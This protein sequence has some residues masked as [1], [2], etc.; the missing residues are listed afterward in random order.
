MNQEAIQTLYSLAVEEGYDGE[1][2]EFFSLLQTNPEAVSTA[3][4]LARDEGYTKSLE[5][6]EVLLGLKKKE[7]NFPD[8]FS[9]KYPSSNLPLDSKSPGEPEGVGIRS[10][11][12]LLRRAGL[13]G[14]TRPIIDEQP[15]EVTDNL[16]QPRE[17][18]PEDIGPKPDIQRIPTRQATAD[19]PLEREKLAQPSPEKLNQTTFGDELLKRSSLSDN[20][21]LIIKDLPSES[22]GGM[23]KD[24]SKP[25]L[26]RNLIIGEVIDEISE[27]ENIKNKS[28]LIGLLDANPELVEKVDD[29]LK[30]KLEAY[31][32]TTQDDSFWKYRSFEPTKDIHASRMLGDRTRQ[33]GEDDPADPKK[34]NIVQQLF[35]GLQ[36]VNLTELTNYIDEDVVMPQGTS[37]RNRVIEAVQEGNLDVL[38]LLDPQNQDA[39][40]IERN[41]LALDIE[42]QRTLRLYVEDKISFLNDRLSILQ[43]NP[44]KYTDEINKIKQERKDLI[45]SF[46]SYNR[47]SLPFL[48]TYLHSRKQELADKYVSGDMGLYNPGDII[49]GTWQGAKEIGKGGYGAVVDVSS[50]VL[51]KLGM[52]VWAEDLR[53]HRNL[54]NLLWKDPSSYAWAEGKVVMH[55]GKKYI[56]TPEGQV[57]DEE[58]EVDVAFFGNEAGIDLKAIREKAVKSTK[59]EVTQSMYGSDVLGANVTGNLAVQIVGMKGTGWVLKGLGGMTKAYGLGRMGRM[60]TMR[61]NAMIST[62]AV[63]YSSTY[64]QVLEE[65]REQGLP[66]ALGHKYASEI[67]TTTGLVGAITAVLISP[68]IGGQ[69]LFG[70]LT[71]KE[72]ARHLIKNKT[73]NNIPGKVMDFLRGGFTEGTFEAIQ[74]N[75][76]LISEEYAKQKINAE[77]GKDLFR[78]VLT[79]TSVMNN[80]IA[81]FA[82]AGLLGGAGR[83]GVSQVTFYNRL[84]SNQELFQKYMNMYVSQGLIDQIGA[85]RIVN[86][87]KNYHQYKNNLPKK[88]RFSSV[89]IKLTNLLAE[90]NRLKD[91]LKTQDEVFNE[92]TKTRIAAIDKEITRLSEGAVKGVTPS[93]DIL[94]GRK[95][96]DQEAIDAIAKENEARQARGDEL[97]EFTPENIFNKKQEILKQEQDASKK[98]G[99]V[100]ETSQDESVTTEEVVEGVPDEVQ[101]PSGT[102]DT[103]GQTDTDQTTEEEVKTEDEVVT[104]AESETEAENEAAIDELIKGQPTNKNLILEKPSRNKVVRSIKSLVRRALRRQGVNLNTTTGRARFDKEVNEALK[105]YGKRMETAIKI[106]NLLS[107]VLPTTKIYIAQ[108]SAEYLRLTKQHRGARSTN[109]HGMFIPSINT[110][111]VNGLRGNPIEVLAHEALH[112]ILYRKFGDN[113]AKIRTVTDRMMRELRRTLRNSKS[114]EL[115]ALDETLTKFT[116]RYRGKRSKTQTEEYLVEAFAILVAKYNTIAESSKALKIVEKFVKEVAKVLGIGKLGND[117]AKDPDRVLRALSK[118]AQK[119]KDGEEIVDSDFDILNQIEAEATETGAEATGKVKGEMEVQTEAATDEDVEVVGEVVVDEEVETEEDVTEEVTTEEEVV[120]D[121][122]VT[123]EEEAGVDEDIDMQIADLETEIENVKSELKKD[124]KQKG[125]DADQ[126]AD[127]RE[128]ARELIREY[129]AEIAQLKRDA[130]KTRKTKAEQKI[131]DLEEGIAL[132]KQRLAQA[133]RS[134]KQGSVLILKTEAELREYARELIKEYKSAI[135][136]IKKG[137]TPIEP[138]TWGEE[139][140]TEVKESRIP[141]EEG[142]A[143]KPSS[144]TPDAASTPKLLKTISNTIK[145]AVKESKELQ[146]KMRKDLMIKLRDAYKNGV[147]PVRQVRVLM[148]RLSKLNMDNPL[149]VNRFLEYTKRI[150]ADADNLFKLKTANT[151]RKRLRKIGKSKNIDAEISATAAN[152]ALLDPIY[153][154]DLDRYIE[155]AEELVKGSKTTRVRK[156]KITS[157]KAANLGKINSFVDTQLEIEKAAILKNMQAEFEALTGIDPSDMTY[158]EMMDWLKTNKEPSQKDESIIRKGIKKL[159]DKYSQTIKSMLS[160]GFD[161]A[162]GQK[163]SLDE[164]QRAIIKEFMNMDLDVMNVKDLI[165]A[166]EALNNFIV[167]QTTGGM[168]T[169]V[170]LNKGA[171]NVKGMVDQ[172]LTIKPLRKLKGLYDSLVLPFLKQFATLPMTLKNILGS[173]DNYVKFQVRSGLRD[174]IGGQARAIRE[175]KKIM[176]NYVDKFRNSMPNNEVFTSLLNNLERGVYAFLT[177]TVSGDLDSQKKEFKRRKRL[178]KQSIEKYKTGNREQRKTAEILETIYNKIKDVEST[179]DLDQHFNNTNMEAVRFWHNEWAKVYTDL[180]NVSYQIYNAILGNDVNYTP[181]RYSIFEGDSDIDLDNSSSFN[182]FTGLLFSKKAGVLFE[183]KRPNQLPG[184]RIINFDFDSNMSKAMESAKMDVETAPAYNQIKGFLQS[185]EFKKLIPDENLRKLVVDKITSYIND[186]KKQ[187]YVPGAPDSVYQKA[188]NFIANLGVGR[189]LAGVFQPVKQIVGVALNTIVTAKGNLDAKSL[190]NIDIQ[191]WINKVG[192]SVAIR[193]G[194][195]SADITKLDKFT[196]SKEFMELIKDP[197]NLPKIIKRINDFGLQKFLIN[198]DVAISRISFITYYKQKL[199][200]KGVNVEAIDWK[201]HEADPEALAYAEAQVDIMQNISSSEMFGEFFK[202]KNRAVSNARKLILPFASFAMNLKLRIWTNTA[203]LFSK[204]ANLDEKKLA[205]TALAGAMIEVGAFHTIGAVISM[206]LSKIGYDDD[207]RKRKQR[208]NNIIKGRKGSAVADFLS[209]I[210]SNLVDGQVLRAVNKAYELVTKEEEKIFFDAETST[211]DIYDVAGQ[212]GITL[213]KGGELQQ[214]FNLAYGDGEFTDKWGNKRKI[215]KDSQEELRLQVIPFFMYNLG[216][217]PAEFG[218]VG[219]YKLKSAME[220]GKTKKQR[221]K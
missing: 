197:R 27:F 172:G 137:K 97:I 8:L 40:D 87:V 209:P 34:L 4:D 218:T 162:T 36:G 186:V 12:D 139:Q 32:S 214:M 77:T 181:D 116:Q 220:T 25:L 154:E 52:D 80:T 57:I 203:T 198:P 170:R 101:Q 98:Q 68:N 125:L 73:T 219:R 22:R 153:V 156:G 111:I 182:L 85:D 161:L 115:K 21:K 110:I 205:A 96:K 208:V 58:R 71:A 144:P 143:K 179:A 94:E 92:D 61:T 49:G 28:D 54:N 216:V 109:T 123:T 51:D 166:V 213:E 201:N 193:G 120:V 66:D 191:N 164:S 83:V 62:G 175:T 10:A 202:S 133:L 81:A 149:A 221:S 82:S 33:I 159:F 24:M 6:F 23:S 102:G 135:A 190:F 152:F 180:A 114:D 146:N 56:V 67:A 165:K 168:E 17:I 16:L 95:I 167:N 145:K 11:D 69:Q 79:K 107:K 38:S 46:G 50:T 103:T 141:D 207:E 70:K 126:K 72:I 127:L 44:D 59:T 2:A 53:I 35:P 113:A 88:L 163:L 64:N 86:E 176:D 104:E 122:E 130:K 91:E 194:L 39:D 47:Q 157:K 184:N 171:S 124:L 118:V 63:V 174:F 13:D 192:T 15:P 84:G 158:N 128:Q 48:N 14:K 199:R 188:F 140:T 37:K 183:S 131:K 55:E 18:Q 75:L 41:A 43:S 76:E 169:V 117:L 212:L 187:N 206:G 211:F 217:F 78:P 30:N 26:N 65:A 74:E 196:S 185:P 215:S 29:L 210:P 1:M 121:E 100:E 19:I 132:V 148:E 105:R 134:L 150:L 177:R 189:A 93:P 20:L 90:K 200:D 155:L 60:A 31:I 42:R 3:Y 151:L 106:A 142:E 99:P 45:V 112:A 138:R 7:E 89:A 136:A 147:L 204:T 108:T 129:K 178:L 9:S 173:L 5:N 195:S 160:S 119:L